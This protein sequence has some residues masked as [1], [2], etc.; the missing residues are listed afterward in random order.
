MSN[1]LKAFNNIVNF[2]SNDLSSYSST[3]LIRINAV[4]EQLEYYVKDAFA[5]SFTDKQPKKEKKY[6]EVFS[7]QGSQN[8]PPDLILKRGDAFEIKK[9]GSPKSH[10]QLNSSPPK[11]RLYFTD[12]RITTECKE[13][14][15]EEAWGTKDLFYIIGY[16]LKGKINYLMFAQGV[17]YA[18]PKAV[19]ERLDNALRNRIDSVINSL[20]L[21]KKDTVE[22][23]RVTKVDSLGITDLRIRGMWIIQNPIIAFSDHYQWNENSGFSLVGLMTKS[24][25]DSFPS[26]D[27]HKLENN[28][29]IQVK[30]MKIKDPND[31]ARRMEAKIIAF[32]RQRFSLENFLKAQAKTTK[33]EPSTVN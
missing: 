22:L 15:G 29:Q 2:G 5:N 4:G 17:C 7:Y 19:Y 3:Y 20:G 1:V 23:G 6:S 31:S 24:K 9:I 30:D 32:E 8:N 13:C 33:G 10:I 27:R 14:E 18:A 21:E 11:D 28:D 25:Y 12:P 26:E 16:V